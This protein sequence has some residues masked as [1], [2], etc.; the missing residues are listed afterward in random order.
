MDTETKIM[1]DNI[2]TMI[3]DIGNKLQDMEWNAIKEMK[4]RL[5][6]KDEANQRHQILRAKVTWC[7]E[8][9]KNLME[10]G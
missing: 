6:L 1:I 2:H 4:E 5:I 7:E 8:N 3:K 9:I 10:T